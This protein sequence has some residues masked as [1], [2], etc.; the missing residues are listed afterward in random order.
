MASLD[1]FFSLVAFT[2]HIHNNGGT[3]GQARQEV[4]GEVSKDTALEAA[5]DCC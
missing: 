4:M 2:N 5:H 3:S 1:A